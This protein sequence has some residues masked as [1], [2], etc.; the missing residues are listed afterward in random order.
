M[1]INKKPWYTDY[2]KHRGLLLMLLPCVIFFLVFCYAPM[3]GLIVAFKDYHLD[4]GIL[5][6]PWN[7]LDTFRRLFRG[8]EF[9]LVLRNTLVISGL[10]LGFGFF[11]PIILA[12]LLNEVRV[13]W[14]KRTV[15]TITYLPFF[16][17]WVV[18]GGI[19]LMLFSMNGPVNQ[20]VSWFGLP[21]QEFLTSDGWFI[22]VLITTGIWQ[23][24][25]YGSVIY[26]AALAGISPTLYEAAVVDGAGRWKQTIHITLPSLVPTIVTLF[27]LSLGQILNAGFDQVFNMYNPMVYD[28]SDIFGTY[29]LRRMASMDFSLA[30][31]AGLFKAVVGLALVV[32]ANALAKHISKGEQGVW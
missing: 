6:S 5:R 21:P 8:D 27:I 18:L 24:V 11:A 31:A 15:Q 4:V 19:F 30:T 1:E 2:V 12:L 22:F 23:A 20:I 14:Y 7:G 25:G 10:R 3:G 26:L 32:M 9:L 16:F 28:V 17:S 13:S 29:I